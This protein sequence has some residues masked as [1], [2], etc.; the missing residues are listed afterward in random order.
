MNLF[1]DFEQRIRAAVEASSAPPALAAAAD[2]LDR[3]TAEPPR[4]PAHGDVA[5]NAAMVLAKPLGMKPRELALRIA[6]RLEADPGCRLGRR[7]PG[8]ASSIS[9]SRML[10]GRRSSRRSC[11]PGRAY[12]HSDCRR[13]R[14][15]QRRICLGQPDR[16]DACRPLPRRRGRRRDRQ[17]AGG[18]RPR[19][20][21]ANT[22]STTPAR[23]SMRSPA[24]PILR[25]REALGEDD[26]RDPERA[27]SRRLSEAGRRGAEGGVRRRPAAA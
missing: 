12:G 6:V 11:A 24:R 10:S 23:R 26:R 8:R 18:D 21:R 15:G 7:S 13:R 4:D 2:A 25:Y 17:P 27:L 9:G 3:I 14:E 22:T 19:R 20:S 16:A 1:A 5:T